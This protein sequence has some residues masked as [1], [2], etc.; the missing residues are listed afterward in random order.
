M[1]RSGVQR[2]GLQQSLK[3]SVTAPACTCL[4][5]PSLIRHQLCQ[6]VPAAADSQPFD[7]NCQCCALAL[8]ILKYLLL[9][10]EPDCK[11][12]LDACRFDRQ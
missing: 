9:D 1:L 4:T 8:M 12:S 5:V 7:H 11:R 6:L 3:H 10:R 2:E